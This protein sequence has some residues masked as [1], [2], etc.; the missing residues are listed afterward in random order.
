LTREREAQYLLA[1]VAAIGVGAMLQAMPSVFSVMKLAGGMYLAWM[2][3]KMIKASFTP[4]ASIQIDNGPRSAGKAEPIKLMMQAMLIS[5]S[6][7]KSILFL[8]A[9]FPT[10]LSSSGSTMIQFTVMFATIICI[11][12]LIHGTYAILALRLKGHL[13]SGR[14]R[15]WMSRV[16]GISFLGFGAGFV[17]D[18]QR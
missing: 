11:V 2:G 13:V 8:S 18:S 3:F 7:P 16:S 9:V 12:T 1:L 6:N 15:K 4:L 14:A 17:L 10:F 5:Y